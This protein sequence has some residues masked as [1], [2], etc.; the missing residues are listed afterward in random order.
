MSSEG[1]SSKLWGEGGVVCLRPWRPGGCV[2]GQCPVCP[3]EA[4]CVSIHLYCDK[5]TSCVQHASRLWTWAEVLRGP[6]GPLVRREGCGGSAGLLD[7][8]CPGLS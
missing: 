1:G 2:S 5:L 3:V 8:V 7:L 6:G 4:Q